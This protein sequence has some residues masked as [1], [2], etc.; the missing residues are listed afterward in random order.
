MKHLVFCS[1][2]ALVFSG[3]ASRPTPD[4][5]RTRRRVNF[6]DY[7]FVPTRIGDTHFTPG[8]VR[9]GY[10]VGFVLRLNLSKHLHLQSELNYAFVNY[11]VLAENSGSRR[12]A[13]RTERFSN[14]VHWAS[15]SACCACSAARCSASRNPSGAASH[16]CSRSRFNNGDVGVMGGRA[17]TSANY[18]PL[19]SRATRVRASGTISPPKESP[20]SMPR[21]AAQRRVPFDFSSDTVAEN[22][23]ARRDPP[24][25]A[26]NRA[27]IHTP[28]TSFWHLRS[29]PSSPRPG[30]GLFLTAGNAPQ[31]HLRS[32]RRVNIFFANR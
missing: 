1:L 17:S 18:R 11:N 7:S 6:A 16:S 4:G 13:L 24:Q 10:D 12:I 19:A 30:R 20:E 23:P 28:E 21:R 32:L 31:W 25:Q 3:A 2:L 15:S 26:A 5:R 22:V 27:F 29:L 9:A 8:A 14:L